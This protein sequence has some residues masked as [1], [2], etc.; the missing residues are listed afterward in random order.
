M[1][2]F[3]QRKTPDYSV[4]IIKIVYTVTESKQPASVTSLDSHVAVF[5]LTVFVTSKQH[6]VYVITTLSYVVYEIVHQ[7]V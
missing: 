1:G 2:L 4:S 6:H 5:I 7:M 3:Q